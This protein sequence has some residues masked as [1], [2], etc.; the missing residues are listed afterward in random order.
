MIC[1]ISN[2]SKDNTFN[3]IR[4]LSRQKS[5]LKIVHLNA[6]SLNNKIDEFRYI[7]ISSMVDIICV[8]ETWFHSRVQD[9]IYSLPG[10]TLYR[11]DR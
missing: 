4:I 1:D 5:G 9:S 2:S 10:Y 7:F 3:M 6:Q 8:S 11:A